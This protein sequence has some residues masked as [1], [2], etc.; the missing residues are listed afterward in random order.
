MSAPIEARATRY[1]EVA[2]EGILRNISEAPEGSR[3]A[4]LNQE[5]FKAAAFLRQ[6]LVPSRA[7]LEEALM[8]A[9]SEYVRTDGEHAARHTIKSALDRGEVKSE[10]RWPDDLVHDATEQS[11]NL[12]A[13]DLRGG[14]Q[15]SP[16]LLRKIEIQREQTLAEEEASVQAARDMLEEQGFVEAKHSAFMTDSRHGNSNRLRMRT[17]SVPNSWHKNANASVTS[18]GSGVRSWSV[19]AL[20]NS[21]PITAPTLPCK[22]QLLIFLCVNET[23]R[24]GSGCV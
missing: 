13:L 19:N 18:F 14:G 7:A 9:A 12:D 6:G 23:T 2:Y 24:N 8:A 10:I 1:A 22:K 20:T 11:V 16:E 4:L 5:S 15:M 3:N 21:W 17:R